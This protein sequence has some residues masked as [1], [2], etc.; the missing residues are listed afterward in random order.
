MQ[1][2]TKCEQKT[3]VEPAKHIGEDGENHNYDLST[4][5]K[6][7]VVL[8]VIPLWD[9]GILIIP[10]NKKKTKKKTLNSETCCGLNN[11]RRAVKGSHKKRPDLTKNQFVSQN[12]PTSV[13]SD[14]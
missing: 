14:S 7:L 5:A 11:I 9:P 8:G 13:L 2:F 12:F 4:T 10:K 6:W 3:R 1:L